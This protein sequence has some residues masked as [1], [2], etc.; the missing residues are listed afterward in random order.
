VALPFHYSRIEDCSDK[1]RDRG[2][3]IIVDWIQRIW[4]TELLWKPTEMSSSPL[5]FVRSAR[6]RLVLCI[7]KPYDIAFYKYSI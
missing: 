2:R 1:K 7:E 5:G 3:G 6:E 4:I